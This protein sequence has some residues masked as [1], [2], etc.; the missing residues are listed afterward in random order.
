MDIVFAG[1]GVR[2]LETNDAP[3][4]SKSKMTEENLMDSGSSLILPDQDLSKG[5]EDS[6]ITQL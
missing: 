3:T 6:Y 1:K 2:I 4:F 5:G